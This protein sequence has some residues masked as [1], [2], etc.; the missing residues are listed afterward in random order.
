MNV[1]IHDATRITVERHERD[2]Y[3]WLDVTIYADDGTLSLTVFGDADA[4]LAQLRSVEV[5]RA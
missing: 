3:A 5:D 1:H 4:L 2:G